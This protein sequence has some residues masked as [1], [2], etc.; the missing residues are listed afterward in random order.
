VGIDIVKY[1]YDIGDLVMYKSYSGNTKTLEIVT[2]LVVKRDIQSHFWYEE[3]E[4]R[5]FHSGQEFLVYE[6]ASEQGTSLVTE[7]E[8]VK[9]VSSKSS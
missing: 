5:V 8:I 6:I 1:K 9:L 2:G 7:R 3:A 4:R